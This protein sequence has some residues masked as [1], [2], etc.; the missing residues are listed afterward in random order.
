MFDALLNSRI[1]ED[2]INLNPYIADIEELNKSALDGF[3]D[4]SKISFAVYP[5]ISEQYQFLT[6]G[7]ALGYNNGPLIVSKKKIYPDELFDT[8]IAIPGYHTT[9]NLLLTILFPDVRNKKEYLFSDVEEAI[10]SNEVD[11]GLIIHE[12]RF[13]YEKKGLLKVEDLGESWEA[14]FKTPVP[15]GGI[16]I[17]REIP[18]QIKQQVNI[19]ISQSIEFARTHPEAS[20]LFVKSH[21]KELADEVIS[22]HIDLYVN[23][24]SIELGEKGRKAIKFLYE[25]GR[26]AG[27]FSLGDKELFV[28]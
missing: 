8:Q 12:S 17:R 20:R 26:E 25:K 21:A 18:L 27:L 16:V 4:I 23:D 2:N 5:E 1:H 14:K 19:L 28:E 11:A 13:T 22:R 9:A 6:S 24:F 7:S 10:L 15:L 3:P